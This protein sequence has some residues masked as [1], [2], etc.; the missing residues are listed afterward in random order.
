MSNNKGRTYAYV[1]YG[2]TRHISC[3]LFPWTCAERARE[4]NFNGQNA[5]LSSC[6]T[7]QISSMPFSKVKLT[8]REI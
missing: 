4:L 1:A 3:T 8:R 6:I 5:I 7:L 2:V